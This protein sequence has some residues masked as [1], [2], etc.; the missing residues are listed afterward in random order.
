MAS[1]LGSDL[2][3]GLPAFHAYTGSDYTAAFYS[4]GKLRPFKLF[5]TNQTYQKYFSSLTDEADIFIG[6]KMKEI[7]EFTSAMYGI[8]NCNEVNNARY[9]IFVKTFSAKENNENFLRKV[10]TFDSN[11]IPPCWESLKQ[12]ILRTIFVN[13]MWL[14]AT[15]PN[16]VKLDPKNCG[17]FLDGYLKPKGYDG[18]Q[19]PLKINDILEMTEIEND[20]ASSDLENYTTSGDSDSE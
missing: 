6:E 3:L 11:T 7:Q 10:K 12:K 14:H 13:S 8:K 2:C 20:E 1:K 18:D 4:K 19:T 9:Q 15:D 5:S 17:W 16:C